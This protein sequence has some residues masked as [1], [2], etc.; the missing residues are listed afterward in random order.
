MTTSGTMRARVLV[1]G[2]AITIGRL[3]LPCI[4]GDVKSSTGNILFDVNS[5][6]PAE[7]TL[8]TTGLGIGTTSPSAN[9]HIVGN[10]II[11]N[12]NLGLGTTSPRSALEIV[13]S[14]GWDT[15]SVSANT[16]L[17]A[18]G[19]I[20]ADTSSDNITLHLPYAGN[21]TGRVYVIKKT[22]TSNSVYLTG[23]GN[24]IDD[25]GSLDLTT[26]TNGLPFAQVVSDGTQWYVLGKN[27]EA[28]TVASSNLVGWWKLDETSGTTAVDSSGNGNSGRVTGGSDSDWSAGK[29]KNA[30]KFNGVA[31]SAGDYI[32]C[33]NSALHQ[34]TSYFSITAWYLC[35]SGTTND[36]HLVY[37][38]RSTGTANGAFWGY[39]LR[40]D[41]SGSQVSR[42]Q[43]Q[44]GN[45]T[46]S[47]DLY[48]VSN[49]LSSG[50]GIWNHV[51][52]VFNNGNIQ[53]YINGSLGNSAVISAPKS[54]SYV[55]MDNLCLGGNTGTIREINGK[56]DDVRFYNKALSAQE[57]ISIYGQVP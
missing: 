16:S 35:S 52:G 55:G 24:A 57:I 21:S 37:K 50:N 26:S 11:M 9:L 32:D 30:R 33:G 28:G 15:Q 43:F 27:S 31:N 45:G 17:S 6:S 38:Q 4:T 29:L 46:T 2:I 14:L 10:A 13:G 25:L 42:L 3:L 56:L 53:I 12:G 22:S 47:Y 34:Q 54:I 51:A 8:T 5:S 7:V 23:G 48:S 19:Q 1:W 18:N 20:L 44:V 40:T 36:T 39:T 49:A 41:D